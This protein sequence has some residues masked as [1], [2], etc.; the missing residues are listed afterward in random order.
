MRALLPLLVGVPLV[1]AL[2]LALLP[3]LGGRGALAVG[4]VTTGLTFVVSLV[5]LA[6]FD[7]GAGGRQQYAVD[8]AWIT[9][10]GARFHL[11]VD[12][13]SLPLVV[14]TTL[15]SFACAV[16]TTRSATPQPRA[17]MA[18]MLLLEVGMLGTFV[19]LDLLLFFVF[20]EVVLVPM[21]FLIAVWGGERRAYAATKFF[22]YT[23][24]GSVF[25]LLGVLA[26]HART[27]TFD[28]VAL[29]SRHGAGLSTGFQDLCF[30]GLFLAFA[31]KSPL[32]PLHT[33]LPDAHTEAPTIGSV[34]LAGVL[35]KMGTYGFI[36]IALPDLPRGAHDFAP[37]LGILAVVAII[38]GSLCC[39]A[40]RDLKRLI[41]FSSVGHMGFVLLGIA[42]LT[43]VGVNAALYGN[44]A[45]GLITGLLFFL[46]GSLKDRYGTVQIAEIGGGVLAKSRYLGGLLTFV[47]IASLGLPGLAGFWGEM[48][49]LLGAYQPAAG[50]SR[51]LFLV[52]M[53]VGGM[54]T[55]LTAAYFVVMLRRVNLGVVPQR[56]RDVRFADVGTIE[57]A[58]WAPLL[59]LVLALGLYPR[60]VLGVT[61]GAVRALL[62]AAP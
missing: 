9:S 8:T 6:R 24:L 15:L 51:G 62:G 52:L 28:M 1:G 53:A 18:L 46:V 55:V 21:Y 48:L 12:G 61:D 43:P 31:I 14:L 39:L 41:A 3:R 16:Y 44:I 36:R 23:L 54:G 38:Y 59:A 20:F 25:L 57:L 26:L 11:G 27:G 60:L 13:I 30:A 58:V 37:L 4:V 2:V 22:L 50:L 56:W 29:A 7:F 34:L 40:Q 47:A 32:W 42:T 45:H 33:W 10:I 17:L 19:A 49:A 5:A 35:L